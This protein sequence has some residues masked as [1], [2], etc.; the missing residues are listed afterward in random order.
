MKLFYRFFLF[1]SVFSFL[2]IS[3]C[4]KEDLPDGPTPASVTLYSG[5]AG[6]TTGIVSQVVDPDNGTITDIYGTYDGSGAAATITS[7]RVRRANNDTIVTLVIDPTTNNFERAVI[8]VSGQRIDYLVTF[9]FPEGD[10]SMVLNHYN[11]D[12]STGDHQLI[13]AGEYYI[14][15]GTAG[16]QPVQLRLDGTQ[17]FIANAAA[18][19][20]G[21][22]VGI[23]V[24]EIAVATGVIGGSS[25]V[26]TAVGAVA[27]AVAA[28]SSATILTVVAVGVSLYALTNNA[29]ASEPLPNNSASEGTPTSNT[30][31]EEPP[32]NPP[33]P[34][35]CLENR[36]RVSVGVDS[37]NQLVA[38]AQGGDNGPY[39]F[40]WSNGQTG[41]GSVSHTVQVAQPGVYSATAVD[42]NGCAG[43]GSAYVGPQ[44]TL[45]EKLTQWGPWRSADDLIGEQEEPGFYVFT[46]SGLNCFCFQIDY[47]VYTTGEEYEL[48]GSSSSCIQEI[49]TPNILGFGYPTCPYGG[50]PN[51]AESAIAILSVTPQA[52]SLDA[53]L[54]SGDGVINC[55]PFQ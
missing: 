35:P 41:T 3:S 4:K 10:T 1:V 18:L 24:A 37:N 39:D 21:L 46:F 53:D 44:L 52:M 42:G 19:A 38:I 8:E 36:V 47:Y 6:Q 45:M 33:V 5:L 7:F 54:D 29:G 48:S 49:G 51:D 43:S 34:N 2:T 50:D 55:S 28:V 25:L 17:D 22:G 16:E 14:S 26:G 20:T 31:N 27:T 32:L 40:Y 11:Y 23:G 15:Q 9:E 30:I 13:Y 12:W